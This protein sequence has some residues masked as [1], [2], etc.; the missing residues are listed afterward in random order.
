M[1]HYE[2]YG[3]RKASGVPGLTPPNILL[4]DLRESISQCAEE[5]TNCSFW[6]PDLLVPFGLLCLLLLCVMTRV[7][8]WKIPI[9]KR[10]SRRL[11]K[12]EKYNTS[13]DAEWIF[14][15]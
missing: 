7:E 8:E 11:L 9:T 3:R 15:M 2:L 14:G 12:F 13:L 1:D 6:P 4:I 10:K 5:V